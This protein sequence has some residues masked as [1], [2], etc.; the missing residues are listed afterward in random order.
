MRSSTSNI[1]SQHTT[2]NA[3]ALLFLKQVGITSALVFSSSS[4]MLPK[5][6]TDDTDYSISPIP[7]NNSEEDT[8]M[9]Y[10]V[11]GDIQTLTSHPNNIIELLKQ[12]YVIQDDTTLDKFL[13]DHLYLVETLHE[14]TPHIRKHFGAN[15]KVLLKVK[16]DRE[17]PDLFEHLFAYIKTD[18][19]VSDALTRFLALNREWCLKQPAQI[20]KY[21]S[22]NL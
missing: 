5:T 20:R 22:I 21:F 7:Q 1:S 4:T 12:D 2:E 15:A 9:F 11:N 13:S 16:E 17:S 18:L 8:G 19:P 3:I 14:A 10:S 6:Y